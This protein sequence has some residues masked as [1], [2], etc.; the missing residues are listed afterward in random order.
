[1]RTLIKTI[2]FAGIITVASGCGG[3]GGT[4]VSG[5]IAKD[6]IDGGD[7]GNM[8]DQAKEDSA[9]RGNEAETVAEVMSDGEVQQEDVFEVTTDTIETEG[10]E[11]VLECPGNLF[12]PCSSNNECFSSFCVETMEGN[13]CTAKCLEEGDCPRG[14]QCAVCG[15]TGSDYQYCCVPPFQR[16][17]RPCR[18][19]QDCI[20]SLGALTTKYVCLDFGGEKG[21][22]CGVPCQSDV[23]CPQNFVCAEITGAGKQ[24]VP[25]SGECPCTDNYKQYV[26]DCYKSNS[27]GKCYGTRTCDTVCSAREPAPESCNLE[28]DDCNG[29]VDDNV[30]SEP[31]PLT[32]TYGTCT[33][34]T[35]CVN[36]EKICQGSYASPEVCNGK[37]DNCDGVTDEGFPDLDRDGIADCV[38]PDIDGDGV[39]NTQDNCPYVQNPD[40]LDNDHDGIGDACDPDDDNDGVPDEIDNCRF[41]PNPTQ[42]DNDKDGIGDECDPDDDNDSVLDNQDNC[43]LVPNA[44]QADLDKDGI[45][46]ACDDDID[47]DGVP[48]IS[49]NCPYVPNPDQADNEH[50]G[51]G[52]VCDTDDDND[53]IPDDRDNCPFVANKDQSDVDNDGKGDLCDCDADGDG[54]PNEAWGCE[55]PNPKDNCP[56]TY[57]PDQT[58]ANH[59]G[60][61]DACEWDWDNDGINN[62]DDNCP[63]TFNPLQEDMDLDGIGD[64]C[65]S[66][67]DGD[68]LPNENDNCPRVANPSQADM[69]NDGIGDV[70]DD[71][72]DGDG[73]PNTSDCE[74]LNPLVSHYAIEKCNGIDDNCNGQTDEERASGQCGIDGYRTYFY[75]G[76]NDGYGKDL[77]KCLCSPQGFFRALVAGDCD[78]NDPQRNPGVQEICN[79][80]KDDNCNG[81][82]NDEN[83]INCLMYYADRDNDGYGVD[84]D[85]KCLCFAVGDYKTKI[86]GDCNDNDASVNPGKDEICY[87]GKDDNCNGTQN[88]EGA[89]GSKPFYWD[90]DGDGYGTTAYKYFCYA[91]ENWRAERT[92]DCNDSDPQVYP[93]RSEVCNNGKDDNCD[94]MQ[95]TEGA[96]GCQFYYYDGDGDNYG[97]DSNSK[98]LCGPAGRYSTRTAGDCNDQDSSI[99]PGA[100]EACNGKDDN[101]NGQTDDGDPVAMCGT[102]PNGSPACVGGQ[103]KIGSCSQG[104]YDVDGQFSNGCECQWDTYDA[105]GAN[106]CD[107]AYDLGQIT[108]ADPTRIV[109]VNAR[110]V[111]GSDVDWFKIRMVDSSDGGSIGSPGAD[112]YYFRAQIVAPSPNNGAFLLEVRRGSCQNASQCQSFDTYSWYT[113]FSNANGGENPCVTRPGPRL[114]DCCASSDNGCGTGGVNAHPCCQSSESTFCYGYH[115]CVDDSAYYYIKVYRATPPA[116]CND[117]QYTLQI[118]PTR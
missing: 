30:P 79:N 97:I 83:A 74:P 45:G 42:L 94:G 76:D 99:N 62:D 118:R 89:V 64:A 112:K 57:N 67:I 50:D 8:W 88:D 10:E 37:D 4:P 77:S 92:G 7:Q 17:C 3:G 65:D 87:N 36:G 41:I 19:D 40:Q 61:G 84:S 107:H 52:D 15:S 9:D 102:V 55:P 68:G 75:D 16:L 73:D 108:D 48:N 113:D 70:C 33:G 82:E 81:S 25:M 101:C 110:I 106:D 39:L 105:Q 34:R 63:W 13:V 31:C 114:W 54:I 98:C 109:T 71:D 24:C 14:W 103:C 38:D 43:P 20:P 60:I 85:F 51:I 27:Y 104:Y 47:G 28:D 22:F 90:A 44:D 116:T 86:A 49:D 5:D 29:K 93:G 100:R 35:L 1:M 115:Y 58:D 2:F 80:G 6:A 18:S 21:K 117:T 32:N 91:S 56:Y 26:T 23:N 72:I 12:C 46:D 69:D 11:I 59:N 78:D 66:D 95:D 111:P 96:D 53:G